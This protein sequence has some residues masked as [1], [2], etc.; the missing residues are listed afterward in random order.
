MNQKEILMEI[1]NHMQNISIHLDAVTTT[2]ALLAAK[3]LSVKEIEDVF[4]AVTSRLRRNDYKEDKIAEVI[5]RVKL[6]ILDIKKAY[7]A[8]KQ[9]K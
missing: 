7:N 1:T 5:T 9:S 2:N 6:P 4:E 8:A 3:F